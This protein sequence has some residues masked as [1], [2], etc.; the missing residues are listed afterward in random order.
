M[1]AVANDYTTVEASGDTEDNDDYETMKIME[2]SQPDTQEEK[3]TAEVECYVKVRDALQSGEDEEDDNYEPMV[4]LAISQPDT[5]DKVTDPDGYVSARLLDSP[6]PITPQAVEDTEPYV[7]MQPAQSAAQ[8]IEIDGYVNARSPHEPISTDRDK[9]AE[10]NQYV[11]MRSQTGSNF[12][13]RD[14]VGYDT[15]RTLSASLPTRKK[16]GEGDGYDTVRMFALIRPSPKP[17]GK[18]KKKKTREPSL[19]EDGYENARI[20]ATSPPPELPPKGSDLTDDGYENS[21]LLATASPPELPP[22]G[23]DLTDDGYENSRL[24]ATASPPSS[25]PPTTAEESPY[26]IMKLQ[27]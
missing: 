16:E 13:A 24:L 6:E 5:K 9:E 25:P 3:E 11:A 23:S 12:T 14:S 22:I 21:R 20:L 10:H 18:K 2:S 15:A 26:E 8:D 19:T 17:A 7:A 4:P 1:T 27:Q